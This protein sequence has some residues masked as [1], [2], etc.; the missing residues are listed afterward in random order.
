MKNNHLFDDETQKNYLKNNEEQMKIHS[1]LLNLKK[2]K[3]T[4]NNTILIS[5]DFVLNENNFWE[6]ESID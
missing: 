6:Q 5:I 2:L 1:K 4:K 3:L